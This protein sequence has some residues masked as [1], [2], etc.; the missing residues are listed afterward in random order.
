LNILRTV[1]ETVL[2]HWLHVNI[3]ASLH[4]LLSSICNHLVATEIGQCRQHVVTTNKTFSKEKRR[5]W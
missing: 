1:S 2:S 3:F 5:F 4:I